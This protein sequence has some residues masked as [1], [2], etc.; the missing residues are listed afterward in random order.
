MSKVLGFLKSSDYFKRKYIVFVEEALK[1]RINAEVFQSLNLFT[2]LKSNKCLCR[3]KRQNR[4][5]YKL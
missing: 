2:I 3:A 1:T 5:R 4:A